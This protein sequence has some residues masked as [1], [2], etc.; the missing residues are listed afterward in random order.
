MSQDQTQTIYQ[1]KIVSLEVQEGK[2]EVVRH[3]H[4]VA[5]LALR[6]GKMLCVRQLRRAV[7]AH[8]LEV[9]AGLIDDGETPEDAANRELSEETNLQGDMT[10]LT[11]FYSSPG[12]C[13]ELLYVFLAENLRD[14]P[15]TP[16]E[17]EDLTIEW[18]D[19][20]D[21]LSALRDGRELGSASTIAATLFAV[22][23]LQQS[24]EQRRA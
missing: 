3:A 12:F 22:Q 5:I 2:W 21:V 1:G 19:P 13:D 9:P 20:H 10:L 17:D 14:A 24:Q 8:T 4:A 18:H 11:R 16:D 23:H 6:N 7:G 15:G